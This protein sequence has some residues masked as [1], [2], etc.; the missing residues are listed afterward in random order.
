MIPLSFRLAVLQMAAATFLLASLLASFPSAASQGFGNVGR[1]LFVTAADSTR[2]TAVDT[3]DDR[4]IGTIDLGLQP[5]RM[6]ASAAL[7][8]LVTADAH[9]RRMTVTELATL[10]VKSLD[11]DF[12]PTRL[13]ISPDGL[14]LAAG[15]DDAGIIALFDLLFLRPTGRITGLPPPVR[16]VI[17]SGD[18]QRLFVATRGPEGIAI[19]DTVAGRVQGHIK[20]PPTATLVRS[21]T[22]RDGFAKGE[23]S[24]VISQIRLDSGAVLGTLPVGAA[25]TVFPTG[26]GRFL[27][28][29][30][31]A[32]GRLTIAQTQPLAVAAVLDA[33]SGA[34]RVYSA[35]L[36]TVA[37]LPAPGQRKLLVYDLDRLVRVRDIPLDGSPGLGTVTPDGSKL[38]LPVVETGQLAVIDARTRRLIHTIDV[39]PR[40][41]AAM[42]AGSY[43]ICH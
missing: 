17:F 38:F 32:A 3:E 11:V 22:G 16:D 8:K 35:W 7:A 5:R 4:V 23:G 15:N 42:M 26:L 2:I 9:S 19:V 20:G 10:S 36:D 25:A 14:R 39:G 40:P 18:S 13:L 12:T 43:G 37:F 21:A 29:P 6:E 33:A 30:D 31:A 34:T 24:P 27:L 1:T 41:I 28:A